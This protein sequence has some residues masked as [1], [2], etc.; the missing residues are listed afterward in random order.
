MGAILKIT[1]HM[2]IEYD[3]IAKGR[4]AS[5]RVQTDSE[6]LGA[7]NVL[8]REQGKEIVTRHVEM[9]CALV[10]CV[11]AVQHGVHTCP[12]LCERN[13]SGFILDSLLDSNKEL[14]VF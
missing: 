3:Y 13:D 7:V 14:E 11:E 4:G 6:N 9:N 8:F 1:K 5:T 2:L 10:V 12:S